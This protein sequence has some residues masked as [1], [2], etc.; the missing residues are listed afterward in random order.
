MLFG[1]R[2]ESKGP[3]PTNG[4]ST[5]KTQIK[6]LR[7]KGLLLL[8]IAAAS[9]Y[10]YSRFVFDSQVKSY[11]QKT[12][13]E[14]NGAQVTIGKVESR[15]LKGQFVFSDIQFG[16]PIAPMRN[17]FQVDKVTAEIA[18]APL[19]RKKLNIKQMK[20]EE[21]HYWTPRQEPGTFSDEMSLAV[22]KAALL[23]RASSGIYSGIRNELTDNP[24][25]HL[26]QLG[27]GFTLSS[28]L[29]TITEKLHSI[30]HLRGILNNLRENEAYW[31][32]QKASLP[33]PANMAGLKSRLRQKNKKAISDLNPQAE[34]EQKILETTQELQSL[35]NQITQIST[36]MEKTDEQ[37]KKDVGVVRRELGL[38]N[39][40]YKDITHLTFGPTWLS[41]IEKLSYWLEFSRSRSPVG[42]RTENYAVTVIHQKNG[43]SVHF[44]KT[45]ASP[46]F[47]LD[48]ASIVS[49]NDKNSKAVRI[50]GA[51]TGVTSDPAL[52]GKPT[53]FRV[54]ADYPE[55]HFRHFE[56]SGIVDHT[57]TLPR[58]SFQ[59]TLPS[60]LLQEWPITRTPDVS[61]EIKRALAGLTVMGNFEGDKVDLDWEINLSETEYGIDSRFRQVEM[62]L[63]NLLGNLYSFNVI[64][65]LKGPLNNI[66]FTSSSDL[67]KRLAEGLKSEFR[68][69]FG[70]LDEAIETET[71]N[72]LPPLQNDIR[73]RLHKL[74]TELV[75][76][77]ETSLRQLNGLL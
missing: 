47:L 34:L 59:L 62:T 42:K 38:P 3:T 12:L 36:E 29:G 35:R 41:L 67:G 1:S 40:E 26:G 31:E 55:K 11:I 50:E 16:N 39:I 18:V 6:F 23:D 7:T 37:V 53:R 5:I 17:T 72:L 21:V 70:A 69:E 65:E 48:K 14:L 52:Y 2:L 75:P 54:S 32:R 74:E 63:E 58:E 71:R 73:A 4:D 61:L 68:H 19:L 51:I 28:K 24:L 46:T 60:F 8:I 76:Q 13:S 27:S 77:F 30:R 64:G 10:L 45:G 33:S 9:A 49:G 20:V 22:V 43:R 57:Q 56:L 15:L 66:K 44:G 25:R